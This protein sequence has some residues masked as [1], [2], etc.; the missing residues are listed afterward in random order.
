MRLIDAD[1]YLKKICKYEA[2]GCGSCKFQTVCPVDEPTVKAIPIEW[3]KRLQGR[4][5]EA[6]CNMSVCV[7]NEILNLWEKENEAD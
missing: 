5:L 2:D 3:L 1:I 4:Y 6:E 7:V